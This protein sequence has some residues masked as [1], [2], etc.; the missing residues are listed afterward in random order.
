MDQAYARL[1]KFKVNGISRGPQRIPDWNKA[2]AGVRAYYFK[3]PDNHPLELIYFPPGKG[4]PRWQ[5]KTGRLFLGIDHTAIA[6]SDTEKS[7]KFYHDLLGLK[8]AGNSL[9]YGIEQERLNRVPGSRVRITSLRA[10]E[11]PGIEFLE[12]LTPRDGKPY[13]RDAKPNDILFWQIQLN[14]DRLDKLFALYGQNTKHSALVRDPD[15]HALKLKFG[16]GGD[17]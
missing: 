12:Y 7:L 11:G 4:R 10:P 9:N 8:I 1:Q 2:A 3:D 5:E 14:F 15:G 16:K 17:S 6:V 13:P